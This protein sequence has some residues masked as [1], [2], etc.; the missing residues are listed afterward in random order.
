MNNPKLVGIAATVLVVAVVVAGLFAVGSPSTAREIRADEQR[1][2]HL[3][4]LHHEL[5]RH[6]SDEGSLPDSLE[7]LDRVSRFGPAPFDSRRDP[8]TGELFEYSKLSDSEYEVCAVFNTSDQDRRDYGPFPQLQHD[9]GRNCYEREADEELFGPRPPDPRP[10]PV[11]PSE[12]VEATPT[13]E[14][15]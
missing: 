13:P 6:V 15:A 9:P 7:E 2:M 1:R 5:S 8:E 12:T 10:E 3:M 11:T 4:E 14:D